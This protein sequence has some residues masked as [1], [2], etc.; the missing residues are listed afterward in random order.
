MCIARVRAAPSLPPWYCT[1]TPIA[2]GRSVARL[3]RYTAVGPSKRANRERTSFSPMRADSASISFSTVWPST[4]TAS[5]PSTSAGF[6]SIAISSRRWTRATN[7]AFLATKSVS[8]SSSSS[9]P[10][11]LT[12]TP[13]VVE[14]SRRLPTSLAPLMRSS[15]IALSYSPSASVKAF[16]ASIMPAP[17]AS[18][19]RLTSAAVKSA[20]S[21]PLGG[22]YGVW[23]LSAVLGALG[24]GRVV[25]GGR[26]ALDGGDLPRGDR[27]RLGR[28][29]GQRGGGAVL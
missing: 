28:S 27:D 22:A 13:L 6:C 4:S 29:L 24:A 3:C 8:Q 26:H 21:L 11:L 23:R 10:P 1:A 5:R 20:M 9:A 19:R 17:V 18:R 2:G 16:L 7:S 12:T 14:R 15:S 25:A